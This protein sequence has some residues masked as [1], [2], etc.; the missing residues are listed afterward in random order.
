ME[1]ENW[2]EDKIYFIHFSN[3]VQLKNL[4]V[5]KQI[6]HQFIQKKKKKKKN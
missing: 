1:K 4:K 3:S 2:K 6:E 5:R